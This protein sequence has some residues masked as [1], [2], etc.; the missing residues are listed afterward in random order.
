[1]STTAPTPV[2]RNIFDEPDID[3]LPDVHQ[4]VCGFFYLHGIN[5][6]IVVGGRYENG[7]PV[8]SCATVESIEGDSKVRVTFETIVLAEGETQWTT[9]LSDS[10]GVPIPAGID[11]G[12]GGQVHKVRQPAHLDVPVWEV[13][14]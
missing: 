10:R 4:R 13:A 14:L 11:C 1:M 8:E 9:A 3:R 7:R 12:H 5:P 6:A 2:P